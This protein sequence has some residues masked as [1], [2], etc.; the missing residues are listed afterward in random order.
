M[1]CRR[2]H[3]GSAL[4]FSPRKAVAVLLLFFAASTYMRRRNKGFASAAVSRRHKCCFRPLCFADP[5]CFSIPFVRRST[6]LPAYHRPGGAR[7]ADAGAQGVGAAR[8]PELRRV[9]AAPAD[10]QPLVSQ[11]H[12]KGEIRVLCDIACIPMRRP[13]RGVLLLWLKCAARWWGHRRMLRVVRAHAA[14][15]DVCEASCL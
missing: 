14:S 9:P 2:A 15:G 11:R 6:P 13:T 12:H 10:H 5:F 8:S 3:F 4:L 1:N 7:A